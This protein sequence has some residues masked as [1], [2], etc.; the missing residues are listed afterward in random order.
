MWKNFAELLTIQTFFPAEIFTEIW[1]KVR[2]IQTKRKLEIEL[3]WNFTKKFQGSFKLEQIGK[4]NILTQ[5]PIELSIF[6]L[7][8]IN[9]SPYTF[10]SFICNKNS[11]NIFSKL[12]SHRIQCWINDCSAIEW[13][14]ERPWKLNKQTSI[15]F[16]R[17]LFPTPVRAISPHASTNY[18]NQPFTPFKLNFRML[19]PGWLKKLESIKLTTSL[20]RVFHQT[21]SFGRSERKF[22]I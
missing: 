14:M 20:H 13:K 22:K 5:S 12:C 15:L 16:Q 1:I 7:Y 2:K 17:Q 10:K 9:L 21:A 19:V 3:Y 4:W 18:P 8:S 6:K 11:T